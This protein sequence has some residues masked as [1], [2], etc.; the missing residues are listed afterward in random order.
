M[1]SSLLIRI[2]TILGIYLGLKYFGGDIGRKILYPINLFVTFLHEFGHA[3]GAV[4]TGGSVENVQVNQDGSGFTRTIGGNRAVTLMGGYLGSAIFGNILFLVGAKMKPLI[5]PFIGILASGMIFTAI[6]WFNSVFTTSFLIGFALILFLIIWKT[7]FGREVLMF[8]GLASIIFIIQDFNVG[9]SS[10][11]KKYAEVM[12]VLP[13]N[14]WMYIWLGLAVI[15]FYFNI[16]IIMKEDKK[17]P[18]DDG[19][20]SFLNMPKSA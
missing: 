18:L 17:G 15:L 1:R 10:D 12:R 8:L 3:L 7:N 5:K 11:L 19:D 9:P 14:I 16:R 2:I 13:A 6:F 20:D 4:I